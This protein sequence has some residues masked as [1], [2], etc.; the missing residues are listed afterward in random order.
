MI[1]WY[2]DDKIVRNT[3]NV[4]IKITETKTTLTIKRVTKEDEGVYTCKANS[5]LGEAKNRAKLYVK[6]NY[7]SLTTFNFQKINLN[8][9][10]N[11]EHGDEHMATEEEVDEKEVID[12][13]K[14]KKTKKKIIRKKHKKETE[15]II[16]NILLKQ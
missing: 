2:H 16:F 10:F 3:S 15:Y 13:K 14:V 8:N 4:Q 1:I 9:N 6:S 7:S 12:E 5:N 11:L